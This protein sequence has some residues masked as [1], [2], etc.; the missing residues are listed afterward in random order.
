MRTG[1]PLWISCR[2]TRGRTEDVKEIFEGIAA[3]R[4][5]LLQD[6]AEEYWGHMKRLREQLEQEAGPGGVEALNASIEAACAGESGRGFAV[7]AGEIRK[8][9]ELTRQSTEHVRAIIA[10]IHGEAERATASMAE[11]SRA[12]ETGRQLAE[13]AGA[14]LMAAASGDGRK[15]EVAGEIARLMESI[16]EV[17]QHNRRIS[18]DAERQMLE[19]Q[20]GMAQVQAT[21]GEAEAISGQLE[22][23]VGQFRLTESRVR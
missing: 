18:A 15:G 13:A 17:S 2:L 14:M 21:A 6:W 16:A 22:G 9:S 3:T 19:L 1:L 20:R 12:V 10:G 7:V 11:G 23:M 5:A 4:A 8:L